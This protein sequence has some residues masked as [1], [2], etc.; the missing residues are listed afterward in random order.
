MRKII[1]VFVA[2]LCIVCFLSSYA[3]VYLSRDEALKRIFSTSE[4]IETKEV[5]LTEDRKKVI[6]KKLGYR[7]TENS[8][9]FYVGKTAGK[10]DGYCFVLSE[11]GKHSL[12]SFIIAITN[13]GY[14]KD[15]AVLESREVKGAKIGRKR[16]LRQFTGK[17]LKD[18]IR[19]RKDIDAISGATVSSAAATRAVRKALVIWQELFLDNGN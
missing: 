9:T 4:K 18:P 14:I 6:E 3:E 5:K 19:L 10:I 1:P 15:I 11:K 7:I 13:E 16:F 8:F 12:I 17:S 2:I